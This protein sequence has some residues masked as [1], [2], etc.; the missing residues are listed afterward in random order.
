M[1][2]TLILVLSL[3]NL[4]SAAQW[5]LM[6]SERFLSA[7]RGQDVEFS[8]D[9]SSETSAEHM[10]VRFFKNQFDTVV[11]LYRDGK[12]Q[13]ATLPEYQGRTT[14]VKDSLAKGH[15][16]LKLAKVI[17]SD[18]GL[19]GCW[20]N[21]QTHSQETIWKL[22]VTVGTSPL[23]SMLELAGEDI[24]LT[25]HT[26][27]WFPQPIVNWKSPQGPP[28]PSESKT[29]KS[30]HDLFDVETSLTVQKSSGS[31]SC[32]VQHPGLSEEL[33]STVWIREAIFQPSPWNTVSVSLSAF[34][35]VICIVIISMKI[36]FT[37]MQGKEQ[38]ELAKLK[39][40]LDKE[41][42]VRHAE[43]RTAQKHAVEVT[44]DPE[45]AHPELYI[46]DLRSVF[47][48]DVPQ[49]VE[50]SEKRFT[51]KCVV[52]SQGFSEGK[53]YWEVDV[54]Y[55]KRWY[56]GVC[57]DDVDRKEKHVTLSP[58]NGYWLLGLWGNKQYFTINP[59]TVNLFPQTPPRRVG[60]FLNLEDGTI[61]FFNIND[62]SLILT[63]EIK[64]QGL[65]RPYIQL[66]MYG[67]EWQH[68]I[69]IC[70]VS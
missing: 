10:E 7:S 66:Q 40:T 22:Q 54:G 12:D 41:E 43:W 24:Q 47:C 6:G 38:A 64:S 35:C 61:S 51:R 34:C 33:E 32:S 21:S 28:F 65:L 30:Q 58:D 53:Q 48:M 5:Q 16:T 37:K 59:Q 29:K 26:S 42:K 46:R 17:P 52:T 69:F 70:P 1:A 63:L 44:L 62:G 15:A 11:H 9:L 4:G 60:I 57:R 18:T 23:I 55:N 2:L 20:F 36:S 25:C 56:L 13:Q 39:E 49:A 8:C 19:Y 31:I 3:L 50:F 27:G 68:P 45:S 14:F 67:K